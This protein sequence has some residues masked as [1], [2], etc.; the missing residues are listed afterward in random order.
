MYYNDSPNILE[1]D[2]YLISPK[3]QHALEFSTSNSDI[4]LSVSNPDIGNPKQKY[5]EHP[6][7]IYLV[8]FRVLNL[9]TKVL[10]YNYVYYPDFFIQILVVYLSRRS[11]TMP[12]IVVRE[13]GEYTCLLDSSLNDILL[14]AG[15]LDLNKLNPQL[16]EFL[17]VIGDSTYL[18]SDWESTFIIINKLSYICDYN[19][20]FKLIN[21]ATKKDYKG[22]AKEIFNSINNYEKLF[23]NL[24]GIEIERPFNIING[25]LFVVKDLNLFIN[26]LTVNGL[27]V[28]CGPQPQRGQVNSITNFLTCLDQDFRRVLYNHNNYHVR[29]GNIDRKYSLTRDK[30]SFK[31]IH[32]NIGRVHYYSTSAKPVKKKRITSKNTVKQNKEFLTNSIFKHLRTFLDNNPINASTQKKIESYILSQYK[33]WQSIKP[34]Y[35]VLDVN[36]DIFTPKFNSFF[37]EK[38]KLIYSYLDKVKHN[39]SISKLKSKNPLSAQNNMYYLNKIINKLENEKIVDFILYNFFKL[40]TYN[41]SEYENITE[42]KFAIDFGNNICREYLVIL[43][44]QYLIS[45]KNIQFSV[46]KTQN[47]DIV[48][49]FEDNTVLYDLIGTRLLVELLIQADLVYEEIIMSK[50]VK[51]K[52]FKILSLNKEVLQ[53]IDTKNLYVVPLKLPMIV[54]PKPYTSKELG[55]YLLNDVE[56]TENLLINKANY[57]QSSGIV[58]GNIIYDM[59]NNINKTSYKINEEVLEFIQEYGV[60]YGLIEDVNQKHPL[61]DIKRNKR[62]D[63]IYRAYKSKIILEQNILGVANTFINMSIYFPVRLDQRGRIYCEPLYFNYQSSELAKSLIS[64]TFPGIINRRDTNAIE[65]FKAYGANCYGHGLDKRS[66][67]KRA[68]WLNNNRADIIDYNNGKLLAKA[69][70]KCLFLAF[71][72]EYT[73]FTEFLEEDSIEFQTYLPIQLDATCNGF[74]H[75][76]LL[77]TETKIFKELNISKT[78]KKDDP[79]DFYSYMKNSLNFIFKENSNNEKLSDIDRVSYNRLNAFPWD[80]KNIKQAIM[81]LPYN[82]SL[83][84]IVK[85][86]KDTLKICEYNKEEYEVYK[87]NEKIRKDNEKIRKDN[88][89]LRKDNEKI[90]KDKRIKKIK[91]I[92]PI[93][94]WFGLS[95]QVIPKRMITDRD[96]DLLGKAINNIINKDFPKITKLSD[97]LLN[98]ADTCNSL[99]I[100]ISWALPHGLH[101]KQSY[102]LTKTA[103]IKPFTYIKSSFKLRVADKTKFDLSKQ[104][105]AL[106]PNLIHSL[107]GTSLSLLYDRFFESHKP[108]VNFYAIHDCFTTTCDKVDSLIDLLKTVYLSLYTEDIYLRNFDKGIIDSIK[109]HYG[110][111]CVYNSDNRTFTIEKKDYRLYDI[112]EV[113]GKNLPT[114]LTSD[115]IKGSQYLVI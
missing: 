63:K 31:N 32:L 75:L 113:L 59:V 7:G 99:G 29:L 93:I 46:W 53:I 36:M 14:N 25:C 80:R 56:K 15:K 66:Y 85:Y 12:S 39:K 13:W 91:K 45:N 30:F 49:P 74:Q 73:R 17:S 115:L 42:L 38:R 69:K 37:L 35:S 44:K 43:Y 79:K 11:S 77:S 20:M 34:S 94:R 55:G 87:E 68:E 8:M 33:G 72:M 24:K 92:K 88:E 76:A 52:Q 114:N 41:N 86:I 112:E 40:V 82:A 28:N 71:C 10:V 51:N 58:K 9:K 54:E 108:I 2:S 67:T 96:I 83:R 104:R 19:L 4:E 110:N 61:E 105:I 84:S 89:I 109:Y 64:F 21:L 103:T 5:K 22:F 78:S 50:E 65:Y 57:K 3:L 101:I 98:V 27:S 60:D 95:D 107:D 26:N 102:L 81:T 47:E 16:N 111:D 6:Q 23:N 18:A 70:N 90:R 100:P 48:Q 62:Q 1:K 97:Y 106:M